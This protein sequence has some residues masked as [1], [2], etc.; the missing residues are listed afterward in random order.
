MSEADKNRVSET[1]ACGEP[2]T[3]VASSV[4]AQHPETLLFRV[5]IL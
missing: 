4:A 1:E 5:I 2:P 3:T